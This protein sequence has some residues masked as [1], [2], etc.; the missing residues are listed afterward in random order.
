MKNPTITVTELMN[1]PW[2]ERSIATCEERGIPQFADGLKPVQRFL[3]YQGFKTAKNKLDKVA[4]IS[5]SI[6]ALGY[7]HGEMSAAGAL[8]SMGA[9]FS[10]NLPLFEGDGS[11]GNVLDP[12]PA[13]ARYIFA[14]LAPYIETV[15]K[16]TELAPANPDPEIIPPLYYLPTIPM[17]LVNGVK[18]IATGYA[19]DIPPHDPVSIIDDL[20][21]LCDGKKMKG[22]EPMYYGFTG[23]V[24]K[25]ID[26]YVLTGK[27]ERKSPIHIVVT[28]LPPIFNTS[29]SYEAVLR[30]LLEKGTIQNFENNSCNDKFIYDIWLKKGT[31]WTDEEVLKNLKLV[32]THTWNL[33]T[34]MPDGKLH[35]WDKETGFEDM[36]KKFYE[37]R[38]PFVQQ[39]IDTKISELAELVKF[40]SGFIKFI[41]GVISGKVKLKEISEEEL[42]SMIIDKFKVPE[43]YADRVMNAPVRTL[44]KERIEKLRKE[45]EE[46]E[47]ELKHLQST[48]AEIEYK[49]DLEELKKVAKQRI[50]E[51][52]G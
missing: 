24:E 33:T 37:F 42:R 18:G 23:T 4:A 40:Y 34:I 10:N 41:E 13:A 52:W 17:C 50:K 9:Y 2:K 36:M 1:G 15:L 6:A 26:H 7:A 8:T 5:G 20:I 28:D 45:M 49:K 29:A 3:I 39:R 12:V 44:T 22:I 32:N 46:A 35:V 16:D 31:R 48:T 43:K 14:K 11:F 25:N 38:L 51:T 30:K 27:W 19:V 21:R 47:N